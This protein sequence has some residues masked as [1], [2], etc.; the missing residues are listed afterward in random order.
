MRSIKTNIEIKVEI[1]N[2]VKI[3][4]VKTK[5]CTN[6]QKSLKIIISLIFRQGDRWEVR[7]EI[8]SHFSS[9]LIWEK[10]RNFFQFP[11]SHEKRKVI[12]LNFSFYMKKKLIFHL[13]KKEKWH[14]FCEK[15]RDF[16]QFLV[17]HEKKKRAFFFNFLE[18][19]RNSLLISFLNDYSV[20]RK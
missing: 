5:F 3:D 18:K 4:V 16:F 11:F 6:N 19:Q 12:F 7:R 15:R 8:E 1:V 20:F 17:A 10:R 14:I 9:L 13:W 2:I